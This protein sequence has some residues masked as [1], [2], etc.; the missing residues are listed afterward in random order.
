MRRN[1]RHDLTTWLD[2]H[3]YHHAHARKQQT[4]HPY[5]AK[6]EAT[7]AVEGPVAKSADWHEGFK[8]GEEAAH[9]EFANYGRASVRATLDQLRAY[10]RR[11]F[12]L[13]QVAGY[14]RVL[15]PV[16]ATYSDARDPLPKGAHVE[17]DT[18][19]YRRNHGSEPKGFANWTFVIGKS[20]YDRSDDPAIYRPAQERGAHKGG[21]VGL[22]YSKAKEYAIAE[23]KRRGMLVVGVAS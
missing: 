14:A 7:R 1:P 3:G 9:E 16:F 18:G 23:A 19:A 17:V 13:G 21:L 12:D 15:E 5:A 4:P 22:P 11:D 10:A 2:Q 6:P 20:S 8:F